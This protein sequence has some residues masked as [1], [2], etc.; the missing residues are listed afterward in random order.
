MKRR[1]EIAMSESAYAASSSVRPRQPGPG[2]AYGHV[3]GGRGD[4]QCWTAEPRALNPRIPVDSG[5]YSPNCEFW[6]REGSM[7]QLL[8]LVQAIW[9][10]LEASFPL[11]VWTELEWGCR[12]LLAAPPPIG[13]GAGRPTSQGRFLASFYRES[14]NCSISG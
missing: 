13:N 6:T 10:A 2:S 3:E 11:V 4:G 1:R 8:A 14:V 7:V 12:C 5:G 9:W